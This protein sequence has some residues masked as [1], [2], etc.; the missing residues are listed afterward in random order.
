MKTLFVLIL[1]ILCI[2]PSIAQA[3]S[4]NT[5]SVTIENLIPFVV[6]NYSSANGKYNITLLVETKSRNFSS[7]ESILLK[8]A[9]KYLSE[10]LSEDDTISIVAYNTLNGVVLNQTPA[11]NLK[12]ILNVINDFGSNISSK[13]KDGITQAYTLANE[14]QKANIKNTVLMVRN[15]NGTSQP[16]TTDIALGNNNITSTAKKEKGNM[17][18]LTALAVLPELIS[19]IKD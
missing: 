19:I 14:N 1:N 16:S 3:Q 17:V 2:V 13:S 8:Q 9:A 6:E 11:K 12:K 18:L 5:Q 7:E 4:V 15:P 10:K